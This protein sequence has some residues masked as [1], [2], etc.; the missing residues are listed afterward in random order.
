MTIETPSPPASSQLPPDEKALF[1][2]ARRL[3]R[4]RWSF[5]TL[6]AAV[7][8]GAITAIV[9]FSSTDGAPRT[10]PGASRAGVLPNGPFA[11]LTLAGPLAVAGDGALYVADVARDR[12]LVCLGDGRFRVVAGDGKAGFSG[13]GGPAVRAELSGISDLAFAP[14]GALYIADGG[15]VRV[16]TPG[17]V[18]RTLAGDGRAP[19]MITVKGDQVPQ[20]IRNGTRALSAPLGST[21]WFARGGALSLA[22]SLSG[23]LY[24]STGSQ[25]LR[26]TAAGTLDAVRIIIKTGP[27]KGLPLYGFGPIAVDTH[28]NID[29]AGINGWSIWRVGPGGVA[30]EVGPGSGARESGGGY[31]ML[32][33]ASNGTVYAEDGP[34]LLRL[35]GLSLVPTFSFSTALHG[36]YFTLTYFAFAPSGTIYADEIPGNTGFEAHQQLLSVSH[37]HTDLVWQQNNRAPK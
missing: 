1:R 36:G 27:L 3:R 4:R 37:G 24:I 15:R 9:V 20:L 33:R 30:R 21:Q 19:R 5:G 11:T 28:G 25:I 32:E 23:Q 7:V 17:G 2:E 13:D 34:T 14:D 8:V 26:L 22:L 16:V 10:A 6:I 31:S 18:I 29:V 12:V 35:S